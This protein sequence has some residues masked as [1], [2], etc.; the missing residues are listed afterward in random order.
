MKATNIKI[1]AFPTSRL[2]EIY[3]TK[4]VKFV[5]LRKTG[6]D[7]YDECH[8]PAKC[9]DYL[10]DIVNTNLT[11]FPTGIYGMSYTKEG[12]PEVDLDVTRY[13]LKF[14]DE[15]S[16]A[17]FQEN[18]PPIIHVIEKNAGLKLTT[19]SQ[20]DKQY[21]VV[22]G[23]PFWVHSTLAVSLYTLLL[24]I[25]AY[26][27]KDP[28]NFREELKPVG[29]NDAQYV[30]KIPAKAWEAILSDVKQFHTPTFCGWPAGSSIDTIHD[31]SGVVSLLC[32][33]PYKDMS[34]NEHYR[35]FQEK[36]LAA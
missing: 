6:K 14:P 34:A 18:V 9:R 11:G 28:S 21:F 4:D 36:G 12:N 7:T 10:H 19:V 5:F 26:E 1:K 24:R 25:C 35:M 13:G 33:N 17:S 32:G 22:E 20:V 31:Y 16:A 23:D 8:V 3:Q 27:Y 30:G 29:G 2:N 15:K